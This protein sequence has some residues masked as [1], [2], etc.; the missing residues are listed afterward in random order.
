MTLKQI[1]ESCPL[2][3][4]VKQH[5]HVIRIELVTG[6]SLI[7]RTTVQDLKTFKCTADMLRNGTPWLQDKSDD[8]LDSIA[9]LVD[10]RSLQ[11]A[12]NVLVVAEQTTLIIQNITNG[13][14][15]YTM[16]V[17]VP[18]MMQILAEYETHANLAVWRTWLETCVLFCYVHG[19]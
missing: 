2:P 18:V 14:Y 11:L 16:Q 3:Y 7:F 10:A 19:K 9:A 4:W 1:A 5:K 13:K 8:V 6:Q 12:Q 15:I 17:L